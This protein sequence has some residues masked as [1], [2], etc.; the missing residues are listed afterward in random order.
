MKVGLPEIGM[1]GLILLAIVGLVGGV[2]MGTHQAWWAQIGA[3]VVMA[4]AIEHADLEIGAIAY[5][6]GI[7]LFAVGC[8]I[9]DI[10]WWFQTGGIEVHMPDMGNPFSVL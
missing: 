7:V 6:P 2:L 10:S 3:L 4:Y 5:L 1:P 8:I 9:G